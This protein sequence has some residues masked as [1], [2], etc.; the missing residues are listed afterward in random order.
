MSDSEF[1]SKLIANDKIK[2][3]NYI[4]KKLSS[5]NLVSIFNDL[6][7]F[8]VLARKRSNSIYHPVIII[9]IIKNLIGDD[10]EQPSKILINFFIDFILD[11]KIR[12]N[13]DY[14]LNQVLLIENA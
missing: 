3:K 13:D 10:K 2:C 6:I 14:L 5:K 8:S 9:N 1:W 11:H 4:N 12:E 7:C